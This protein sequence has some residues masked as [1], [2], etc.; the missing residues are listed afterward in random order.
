VL[1][2]SWLPSRGRC[3]RGQTT[4]DSLKAPLTTCR[5]AGLSHTPRALKSEVFYN[6]NDPETY[7]P[8][9]KALRNIL[10]K[11]NDEMQRDQMKFEDCGGRFPSESASMSHPKNPILVIQVFTQGNPPPPRGAWRV[12]EQGRPGE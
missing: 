1:I 5:P 11:Y 7:L 4:C 3:F 2:T 8:Y 9:T 12:Q 6:R 10:A